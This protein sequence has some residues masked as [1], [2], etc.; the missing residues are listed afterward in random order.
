MKRQKI[1]ETN[2]TIQLEEINQ[3]ILAK[4]RRLQKKK[5]KKKKERDKSQ[6]IQS[7]WNFPI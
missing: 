2:L 5:K 3:K 7:K 4:E 6:V 1:E